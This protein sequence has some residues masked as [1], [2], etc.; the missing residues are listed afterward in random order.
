MASTYLTRSIGTPTSQKIFTFS[1]WLKKSLQDDAGTQ[2]IFD[3]F[4]SADN[5]LVIYFQGSSTDT[6]AMYNR[7]GASETMYM[8]TNMKFRDTN[9]WYHIYI[10][11]DTTQSTASDRVKFYINGEQVTS[12]ETSNYPAQNSNINI[13]SGYTN[14]IGRYGGGGNFFNGCMSHYYYVDGSI[15]DIAQFGSTDSTTGEWKINTSPTIAS[16]GNQGFSILKDNNTI[17]DQSP[18]SNNFTLAGGTLT[19]TEDC[20]SNVF[21]TM[22]PLGTYDGTLSNG[23]TRVQTNQ[24]NYRYIAS[25]LG[26]SSGRYYWECKLQEIGNYMLS[27]ITDQPSFPAS[28]VTMLGNGTYD[29]A[30]YIG[31]QSA[32]GG[33]GHLYHSSTSNSASTNTPGAFM[34]AFNQGDILTF[35][36]DLDSPT[37]K[38]YIGAN[39]Q[40]ANGSGSTNQTFANATGVSIVIPQNT[41]T[42][43]YFPACGDYSGTYGHWEYNFGNGYFGTTAVASA[44]TNASGNGIFEYDVP[45][46]YTA[47]ST[48]GL[49]E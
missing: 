1:T 43:F 38:L 37:R 45:T 27:G 20:P 34:S 14:Y 7:S 32:S 2:H 8:N 48:K 49:N 29:C 25:T 10:A 39:G 16:Y 36:L 46:G 42:G 21:A 15:I 35:A 11:V 19:K 22:N 24:T 41:N 40:W 28:G 3:S 13:V 23:N 12:W 31:N 17:T 33:N 9:G 47:L 18:N 26:V 5:R 4:Y 6:F 30:V 44:G